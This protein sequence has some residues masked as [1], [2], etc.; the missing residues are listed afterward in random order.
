MDG[1]GRLTGVQSRNTKVPVG[2]WPADKRL[3]EI[4]LCNQ[5][6]LASG[7][8]GFGTYVLTNVLGWELAEAEALLVRV[9]G[10]L[11]DRSYHGYCIW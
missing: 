4:G 6:Q 7:V 11:R 10:A 8:D 2:G 1:G 3:K 5:L 9:K